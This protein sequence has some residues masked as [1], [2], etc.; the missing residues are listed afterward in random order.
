[1]AEQQYFYY[2][3]VSDI[4]VKGDIMP[5]ISQSPI[6]FISTAGRGQRKF[7]E[8]GYNLPSIGGLFVDDGRKFVSE[9]FPTDNST[10]TVP[11]RLSVL[12]KT[13]PYTGFFEQFPLESM[14]FDKLMVFRMIQ[15]TAGGRS[16]RRS[17]RSRR[18]RK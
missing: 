5:P 3:A 15:P 17:R 7:L 11:D 8:L 10:G 16:T 9:V 12:F 14:R 4:H 6:G 1:M 18:S 13:N 2:V